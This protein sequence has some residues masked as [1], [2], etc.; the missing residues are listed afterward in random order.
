MPPGHLADLVQGTLVYDRMGT[1][2]GLRGGRAAP[3]RLTDLVQGAL[4]DMEGAALDN[5]L[6]GL[7]PELDLLAARG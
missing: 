5:L 1:Q 4:V 7:Q 6:R 3:E 2:V